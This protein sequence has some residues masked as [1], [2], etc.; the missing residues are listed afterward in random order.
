MAIALKTQQRG[1]SP[2]S[3]LTVLCDLRLLPT[4]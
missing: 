1:Q 2:E 3:Q 4:G